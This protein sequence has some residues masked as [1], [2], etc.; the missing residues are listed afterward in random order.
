MAHQAAADALVS[1]TARLG[2]FRGESRFTTWACKFAIFEVSAKVGRHF[3]RRPQLPYDA[4]DW[5]ALP[6]RFG[7]DPPTGRRRASSCSRCAR[8]STRSSASASA[9]PSSRSCST[10]SRPTRSP[11]SSARTATRSTRR[12]S[13]PAASCV[14]ARR[15]WPSRRS[16]REAVVTERLE[17]FLATDPRD[18]GCAEALRLLHVY[19][20]LV[21]AGDDPEQHHPGI[22]AHLRACE[23]CAPGSRRAAGGPARPDVRTERRARHLRAVRQSAPHGGTMPSLPLSRR[24]ARRRPGGRRRPRG[25]R[26]RAGRPGPR[27]RRHAC[28]SRPTTWPVTPSS[29]TTAAPTGGSTHAGAYPTGGRGGKLDGAVVDNLAVAGLARLRPRARP[30]LRGQRGQR[31]AHRLRRARRPP[32]APPGADL[33]RPLPGQR[34]APRPPPLRPQR[35]RRRLDPGLRRDAAGAD[36]RPRLASRTGPRPDR[37]ARVHPHARAGGVHAGRRPA[38]R[39]HEGQHRCDRRLPLRPRGRARAGGGQPPAGHR[40]VRGRLR[41]GRARPASRRPART[42]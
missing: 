11:S 21:L 18:P 12:S 7:F 38:A 14:T 33:G 25:R 26:P 32:A 19:A 4:E 8:R 42:R 34:H 6:D 20:E 35:P 30:A 15:R 31:H 1:I 13:T 22:T 5:E 24:A 41:R 17:R 37:H 40:P 10:A 9:R 27:A 29:P 28:S 3:W 39:D 23:P 16:A 36:P 2:Q